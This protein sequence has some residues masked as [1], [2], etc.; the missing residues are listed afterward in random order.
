[1][2]YIYILYVPTIHLKAALVAW[3]AFVVRCVHPSLISKP[4]YCHKKKRN[5][6]LLKSLK[7]KK[8][9]QERKPAPREYVE[10]GTID[11]VNLTL[12]GRHGDLQRTLD[13]AEAAGR[14]I[15]A[16]FVEWSG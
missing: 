13:T 3:E 14:P 6:G 11:Y 16:N 12:D 15:F 10:L 9:G 4:W 5:M 2:V 7:Q 8:S 1:M